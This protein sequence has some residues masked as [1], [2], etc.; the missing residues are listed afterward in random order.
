MPRSTKSLTLCRTSAL[1]AITSA[2]MG[3]VATAE[4]LALVEP[5]HRSAA[6]FDIVHDQPAVRPIVRKRLR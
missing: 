6:I 1:A 3:T 4:P 5:T 2:V